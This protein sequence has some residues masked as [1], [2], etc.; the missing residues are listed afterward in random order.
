MNDLVEALRIFSRYGNPDRPFTMSGPRMI[1]NDID[2]E[3][4]SVTDEMELL[5]LG[6]QV[7]TNHNHFYTTAFHIP[8]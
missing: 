3:H 4:V 2:P 1:I 8:S 7:D 5:E 6:F